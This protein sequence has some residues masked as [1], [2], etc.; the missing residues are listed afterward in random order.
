VTFDETNWADDY[1]NEVETHGKAA[2][3]MAKYR[4]SKTLAEK[5]KP[6]IFA[7]AQCRH[8]VL[9]VI[10]VSCMEVLSGLQAEDSVG[11]GRD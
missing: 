8:A 4:A 6:P 3:K 7:I 11:L 5:G 10:I 9:T 2:S 1:V